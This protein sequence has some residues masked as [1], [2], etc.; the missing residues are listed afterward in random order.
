MSN[1]K[2]FL[3]ETIARAEEEEEKAKSLGRKIILGAFEGVVTESPVASGLF[4]TSNLIG[5]NEPIPEAP[6]KPS[7]ARLKEQ[8]NKIEKLELNNGDNIT[9]SN[10]LAYAEALESG[11]STQA[12]QGV[13]GITEDR[14]QQILNKD[15]KV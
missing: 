5:V 3:K 6:E 7:E 4:K 8:E 1:I 12:P 14:I 10:S 13:Y 9:I 11:R 2:E 15:I